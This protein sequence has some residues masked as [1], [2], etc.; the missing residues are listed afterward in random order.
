MAIHNYIRRTS[1]Q[2]VAFIKFDRHLH[3]VPDDFLTGVALHSHIQ[4]NHKP[5][6]MDYIHDEIAAG[7]T[8]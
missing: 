3:F 4:I 7:L 8:I 6:C 2:D 1:L 5:S